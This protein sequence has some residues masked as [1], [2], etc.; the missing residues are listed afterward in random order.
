VHADL[1]G[2]EQSGA[3]AERSRHRRGGD[4]ARLDVRGIADAAQLALLRGLFL[5]GGIALDVR[6]LLRSFERRAVIARVV[7]Q[8]D[9]RLVRKLLHEI[10]PPDLRWIDP[11]LA[12]GGLD[13]PLDHVGR[14]R[15][16]GAA[17]GVDRRGVGE[18][19][20]H[21]TMDVGRPVLAGEQRGVQDRRNA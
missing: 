21:L 18:H 6:K 14:L 15:P 11:E 8:R 5:A 3:R 9:R 12:R 4:S 17:V 1:A 13:Q 2:L 20:S 10:A 16:P 7:L 19:C